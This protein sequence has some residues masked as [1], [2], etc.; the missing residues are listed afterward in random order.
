[1]E[2]TM[3][4]NFGFCELNENEMIMVDGGVTVGNAVI[5]VGCA[6]IGGVVGATRGAA[7]G[8][9]LGAKV[10]AL[11]GLATGVVGT[12]AWVGTFS[13]VL[14]AVGGIAG[15]ALGVCGGATLGNRIYNSIF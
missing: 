4:N 8:A 14:G 9:A 3:T 11:V 12:P 5:V 1:M 6:A 13:G 7:A 15:F 10:G 2:L